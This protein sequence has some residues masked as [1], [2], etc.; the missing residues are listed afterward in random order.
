MIYNA[1]T[2]EFLPNQD[3]M[4]EYPNYPS[5]NLSTGK[6]GYGGFIKLENN[7]NVVIL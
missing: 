3:Y 4:V 5:V 2:R 6:N 1:K 7:Y